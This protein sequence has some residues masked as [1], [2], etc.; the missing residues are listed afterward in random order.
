M[1]Q[2]LVILKTLLLALEDKI[3]SLGRQRAG[4]RHGRFMFE[5]LASLDICFDSLPALADLLRTVGKAGVP[6]RLVGMS[7][8]G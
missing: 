2:D 8:S 1:T 3:D 4:V 7:V 5:L 6:E